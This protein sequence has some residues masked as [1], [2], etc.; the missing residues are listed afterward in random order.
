M[1]QL[2]LPAALVMLTGCAEKIEQALPPETGQSAPARPAQ[3]QP[4]PL[5]Q[6]VTS[7]P[8]PQE[9]RPDTSPTI[10]PAR[11]AP[12]PAATKTVSPFPVKRCMNLGNSLEAP[13]EGEWGFIIQNAD[14]RAIK[15]AGFDTIRLPVRWDTHMGRRAPY[16]VDPAY[17][18]RVAQIVD[19]A[20]TMGLGVVL[21]VHHYEALT[22]NPRS[23]ARRFYAL[24]E[25][26]A[27]RFAGYSDSVYF[28]L[29]NEPL[30]STRMDDVNTLYKNAVG[31]I[32]KTNPDRIVIMGGNTWNAIDTIGDVD[33]AGVGWPKDPN[34]VATYHDYGPHDFTHQGATWTTPVL[35]LGR[36]WGGRADE[37]EFKLTFNQ[38]AAF[39]AKTG[40]RLFV[41]EFGVINQVPLAERNAWMKA[42]RKA[43]E[44]Q[45]TPWCVWNYSATFNVF[46]EQTRQW[47]PG[48]KDALM[49]R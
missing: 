6:P 9:S 14:L 27:R 7:A 24:W 4:E 25:Q 11:P 49:G 10:P 30:R 19:M 36:K 5:P 26:I 48:T 31:I 13:R 34:I 16:T 20:Q 43:M 38:A 46:N 15:G 42:R 12:R 21:D 3:Y 33:W 45:G 44:A 2:I 47:L 40:L 29:F 18:E 41:G 22:K 28:E 23:E 1:R 32:R 37:D 17:M 35:P 8:A 39:K